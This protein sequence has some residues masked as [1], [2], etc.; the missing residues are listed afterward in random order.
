VHYVFGWGL[1]GKIF[2]CYERLASLPR[3]IGVIIL[4][5]WNFAMQREHRMADATHD[6]NSTIVKVLLIQ[7]LTQKMQHPRNNTSK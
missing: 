7:T 3:V 1:S 6:L 2:M 4:E 5:Q